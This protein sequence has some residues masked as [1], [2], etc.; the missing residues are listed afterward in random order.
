MFSNFLQC[1]PTTSLTDLSNEIRPR[2]RCLEVLRPRPTY[3]RLCKHP[4]SKIGRFATWIHRW[5]KVPSLRLLR[6]CWNAKYVFRA[7]FCF[8]ICRPILLRQKLR[9]KLRKGSQMSGAA[10]SCHQHI[11]LF[12]RKIRKL[13]ESCFPTT[14]F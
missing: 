7:G 10:F 5:D 14:C 12:P 3:L 2:V 13:N 1:C 9:I 8:C 4:G 6:R 11:F